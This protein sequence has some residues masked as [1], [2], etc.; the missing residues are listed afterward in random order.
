MDT[1][2][3]E[4]TNG[5]RKLVD[6]PCAEEGNTIADGTGDDGEQQGVFQHVHHVLPIFAGGHLLVLLAEPGE[7]HD[8]HRGNQGGGQRLVQAVGVE[9]GRNRALG[10][11][12]GKA[13]VDEVAQKEQRRIEHGGGAGAQKAPVFLLPKVGTEVEPV[14]FPLDVGQ[15]HGKLQQPAKGGQRR[16]H[17]Q[18]VPHFKEFRQVFEAFVDIKVFVGNAVGIEIGP[19]FPAVRAQMASVEFQ[20][21]SSS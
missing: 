12:G 3:C 13:G 8:A 4:G 21:D 20:H 11:A 7:Q 10:S 6:Q 15:N 16:E 2:R 17:R 5:R 18:T 19:A 9:K 1:F 14:L